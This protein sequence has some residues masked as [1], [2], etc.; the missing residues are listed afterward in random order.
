MLF[1]GPD[2]PE[3]NIMSLGGALLLAMQKPKG[4][5]FEKITNLFVTT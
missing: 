3:H 5:N 4:T 1:L 2:L